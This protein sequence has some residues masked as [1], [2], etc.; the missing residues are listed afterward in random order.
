M[1]G[2]SVVPAAVSAGASEWKAGADEKFFVA[3][4]VADLLRNEPASFLNRKSFTLITQSHLA[5]PRRRLRSASKPSRRACEGH[6]LFTFVNKFL[7]LAQTLL[8]LGQGWANHPLELALKRL[9]GR[10]WPNGV[11]KCRSAYCDE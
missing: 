9:R 3:P 10:L 4:G 8:G 2:Y 5:S 7:E 6:E 11:Y 1:D